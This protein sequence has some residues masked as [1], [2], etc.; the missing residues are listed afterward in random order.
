VN[1]FYSGAPDSAQILVDDT[2]GEHVP[3]DWWRYPPVGRRS[4]RINDLVLK[5]VVFIGRAKTPLRDVPDWVTDEQ[6]EEIEK[7]IHWGGTGF[8]ITVDDPPGQ[9][10]IFNYLVTA[11]H[12]ADAL[13]GTP[14]I[15]RLNLRGGATGYFR[16]P[17][18][19]KWWRHPDT[20]DSVDV[21]VL[22]WM[23]PIEVADFTLMQA[24]EWI[25]TDDIINK[26]NI[27]PGDNVYAVGLFSLAK[28]RARNIPIVRTGHIA[29]MPKEKIPGI[30][31]GHWSGEAEVYLIEARSIGG[32]SGSPVFVRGTLNIKFKAN[33]AG[34]DMLMYG[35]GHPYLLGLVHGHWAIP[36][37]TMN[38]THIKPTGE[39]SEA[40]LGLAIVVPASRIM[41]VLNHPGLIRMRAEAAAKGMG[42]GA[43]Q[44][45]ALGEPPPL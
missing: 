2:L 31:I 34:E 19:A 37:E 15:L 20:P 39:R 30:R 22:P 27:G 6:F 12:V 32:L 25:L 24:H 38:D 7:S 8:F 13:E 35:I 29:M 26:R 44:Q 11:K 5:N 33:P 3:V 18:E 43:S 40:N 14:A 10:L 1:G 36:V 9:P 4:V 16:V 23:P 41:E 45:D 21:A 42:D 17:P 28:G